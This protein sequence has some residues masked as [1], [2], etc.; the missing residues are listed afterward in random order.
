MGNT[1]R[2]KIP[3]SQIKKLKDDP[4]FILILRLCRYINQL[5]YIQEAYLK[6][7]NDQDASP[8]QIRHFHNT[9]FFICGVLHEA[10]EFARG[11]GKE[12][13]IFPSFQKGLA[14]LPKH[15]DVKFLEENEHLKKMRNKF[16]F[17]VDAEPFEE[18]LRTYNVRLIKF[19]WAEGPKAGE[20][21]YNLADELALN[22]Y[23]GDHGSPEE[24]A[25]VQQE[26]LTSAMNA[27]TLFVKGGH[28]LIKEYVERKL[29]KPED[30]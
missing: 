9:F 1:V 20:I 2:V 15:S 10:L 22:Y 11:L 5:T 14:K 16:V 27:L 26:I 8:T 29:W 30:E 28:A 25:K 19:L 12:F 13:K 3:L 18:A 4:Q 24:E 23:I 21:Y 7:R 6:G 17:H